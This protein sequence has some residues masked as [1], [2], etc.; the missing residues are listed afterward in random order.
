MLRILLV[1]REGIQKDYRDLLDWLKLKTLPKTLNMG[2]RFQ[3]LLLLGRGGEG[4]RLVLG[5]ERLL[6]KTPQV[7][8]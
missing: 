3:E 7:L 4:G 2:R 6:F 8:Q 5:A 1:N